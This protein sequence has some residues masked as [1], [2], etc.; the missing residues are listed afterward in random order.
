ME[1]Y[2]ETIVVG[3]RE[4]LVV[5]VGTEMI[6]VVVYGIEVVFVL[7]LVYV[8]T[9]VYVLYLYSVVEDTTVNGYEVVFVTVAV[10]KYESV[11]VVGTNETCVVVVGTITLVV[12]VERLT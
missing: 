2:E 11:M 5:V 10:E 12:R 4:V 7:V 8:E 9:V 3:T 1:K 6:S